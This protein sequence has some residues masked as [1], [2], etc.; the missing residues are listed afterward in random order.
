[1]IIA[2]VG[3]TGV[4]KT[5]LSVELAKHYH[6]IIINC[7]A[8]Q[9]YKGMDIGTAKITEKEKENIPHYLFDIKNV[10]ENYTVY[11]YQVDAR[12]ILEENQD[13]NIIFVGGTGLYLKAALYSYEFSK[14]EKETNNYD[15]LSNEELYALALKKDP[16]M[17]IHVNNRK[18]L[19]RFL[20]K[21]EINIP[22]S[23][24]LYN[25]IYIGLTCNRDVLY[26]RI[27]KR[28]DE[29]FEQGLL[30]EVKS[31]YDAGI[32]SKA[33]KTA[34]GYKEL[35][36]YFDGVITLEEAKELIKKRSRNY[37]KRQYTWFNNQMDI[38]WFDV[39]FKDFNKTVEEVIKYIE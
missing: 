28:V 3:P 20:N 31:F 26:E 17:D 22:P 14:E 12:K 11:D 18:R 39:D 8:M 38:K 6:G 2:V 4:G 24:P 33:L 15:E 1:M 16:H 21:E 36:S 25:V 27:N 10:L 19:V 5:K 35:Y 30:E 29:M 37:A 32:D 7:D 23:K 9:V 13:K 34:I